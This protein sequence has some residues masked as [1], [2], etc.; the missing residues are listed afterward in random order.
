MGWFIS[1]N[2]HIFLLFVVVPLLIF[3]GPCGYA[4]VSVWRGDYFLLFMFIKLLLIIVLDR[5][6]KT[7]LRS[8]DCDPSCFSHNLAENWVSGKA[9]AP[10]LT[11]VMY[12]FRH[13]ASSFLIKHEIHTYSIY[14]HTNTHIAIYVYYIHIHIC[15]ICLCVYKM[16]I[17]KLSI[18][19]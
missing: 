5:V 2:M 19:T 13:S 1:Q 18:S 14:L 12:H 10:W 3:L 4:T 9:S 6:S 8:G 15:A 16:Y 17:Y 7:I 11:L